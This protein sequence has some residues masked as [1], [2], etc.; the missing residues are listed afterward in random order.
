MISRIEG[1]TCSEGVWYRGADE[2]IR[3]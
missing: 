2:S 3:T 1:R